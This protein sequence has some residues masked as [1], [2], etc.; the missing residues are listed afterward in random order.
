MHIPADRVHSIATLGPRVCL[1]LYITAAFAK[2]KKDKTGDEKKVVD[3]AGEEKMAKTS[4]KKYQ[5]LKRKYLKEAG[6]QGKTKKKNNN[7]RK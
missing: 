4:T 7:K 6:E 2:G 5:H 3:K 1:S